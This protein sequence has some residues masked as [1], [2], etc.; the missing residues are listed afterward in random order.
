MQDRNPI[1]L[2]CDFCPY[3]FQRVKTRQFFCKKR[4]SLREFSGD[5]EY[6][7]IPKENTERK[8]LP[9]DWCK[10]RKRKT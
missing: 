6:K 8:Y 2:R 10:L 4:V 3:C 1:P 5:E 7:E 9:P